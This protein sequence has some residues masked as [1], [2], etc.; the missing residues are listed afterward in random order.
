MEKKCDACGSTRFRLSRFR[1]SDVPRIFAFRYPVRC[2]L[3]HARAYASMTWVM[4]Y[5]RRRARHK[6]MAAGE[7]PQG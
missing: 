3:C 5:K 1:I 7:G 6:Q 2:L 4:E